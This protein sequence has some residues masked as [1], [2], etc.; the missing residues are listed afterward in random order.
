MILILNVSL[1]LYFIAKVYF[2]KNNVAINGKKDEVIYGHVGC[3]RPP[4]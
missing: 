1:F 2:K 4:Y 3:A